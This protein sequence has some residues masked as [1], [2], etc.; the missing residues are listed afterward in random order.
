MKTKFDVTGMTCAACQAHVEKSVRKLPGVS[1]VNVNLLQNNMTVEYDDKTL[2]P[3]AIIH[4]VE[5]GGYGASLPGAK[6]AAGQKSAVDQAKEET[7]QM[8]FRL[9]VSFAFL[10]PLFYLSMGHMMGWPLPSLFLG[11]ENAITFAFTQL[12]LS[13]PVAY[14]NRKYFIN[15][16]KSLFHGSP[17]MDSLIAIGSTAAIV[18]GIYAIYKIGYGLGHG[19]AHLVHQYSM[20]LYFETSAMILSLITLGKFLE[21]R[22]KGKTSEAI[23]KLMDL[24]P[25]TA[26]VERDGAEVEIPVEEV[27]PGD[28]LVVRPG[29]SVPVDGVV[30]EG[31]TAIDESALTGESIPVEKEPGD[32]V[33]G[34]TINKTGFFKFRADKVGEDTALAQIIRL[35][36]EASASKAPIAKLADKVSAVFVPAVIAIAVVATIVWLLLGRSFE[37]AM[38]IG[39][40]VLVISCPCALGLATPTAIMVGTG[41]GA[42][43]GILIKSAEALETAKHVDTVV[44]DKTG[45]VTQGKPQVT[46]VI[47]APGVDEKGL[48]SLAAALE[49][50]SE[51]PLAE[52]VL[53]YA[54]G[55]GIAAAPVEGFQAIS[56]RGV[57]ATVAGR[58]AYAGNLEL[59]G[60]NGIVPGALAEQG[61]R[62]AAEGKTPLYF[63]DEQG[64]LGLIAEA[65]VL[66]ESSPAAV[67]EL[68]QMGIDVVMLTGDNST[69]AQA[70]GRQAGIEKVVAGVLPGDKE[71]HV[72]QLQE[73]G[74]K[75][76][77]V[78][79]GINDAPA[80]ARADV[81]IAIGAGT[82]VAIESADVVLM[83]SDL[84][85]V[86]TAIQL[87]K[88]TI[89][90]IKENLF[91][92]LFYNSIG[93]PLAAGV[94]ITTL[95]WKLNPMFGAAAMSLSSVC[96]VSNALRLKFF[97]P[98]RLAYDGSQRIDTTHV[99]VIDANQIEKE[100]H[101]TGGKTMKKTLMI[102]GM[103]CQHCVKHVT[104]ALSAL[105]GCRVD[106]SLENKCAE[107]EMSQEL[108][109]ATL[110]KAVTDAG[111][112]VT[113]IR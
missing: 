7:R 106:V 54:Q 24:A 33:T 2:G 67:R 28:I 97:K 52:A 23:T 58:R 64:P 17:N 20:D 45:T 71:R 36:E 92:A 76:A 112:T 83:R 65:D 93:I 100:Q 35:V 49:K 38:S 56:G 80:L 66:K 15:G 22:S 85:D 111:Y 77:M 84:L 87:S 68:R 51:H 63:A 89:R 110:T 69:T 30:V 95:G 79:D 39:I 34:A 75:V 13:L 44:L 61:A 37:Y 60:E 103:M 16:F 102:D 31:A 27:R 62:L 43:Y 9:I 113:D 10:I 74:K 78:G 47:T 90:N 72:R 40:A 14:V 8:K 96:V 29:Q 1:Q 50:P 18:Y 57:A 105:P 98:K 12:L 3:E 81:G 91:W 108:D 25:K 94:F 59:L 88:A 46:D 26:F 82:D 73:Q 99:E 42:E 107:V 6:G 32:R 109:N 55:Q 86:S 53:Q 104:D 48:L 70:I 4:A 101:E 19:D 11:N 5:A 21:S 41:K